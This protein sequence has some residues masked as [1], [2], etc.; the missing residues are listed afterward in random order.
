MASQSHSVVS[1]ACESN[2]EFVQSCR[3]V[4]Q[5]HAG[6]GGCRAI[7]GLESLGV[8]LSLHVAIYGH[9]Q[10]GSR[11]GA[12]SEAKH[13]AVCNASGAGLTFEPQSTRGK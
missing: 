9:C 8:Q 11:R 7:S 10:F 5:C 12:G 3:R 1:Q 4:Q 2:A 13:L 6:L